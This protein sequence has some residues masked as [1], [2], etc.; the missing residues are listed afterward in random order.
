M[1]RVNEVV[2][3]MGRGRDEEL[4]TEERMGQPGNWRIEERQSSRRQDIFILSPCYFQAEKIAEQ[5]QNTDVARLGWCIV[6][7]YPYL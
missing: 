2:I 6:R 3:R 1:P 4:S 5:T 7:L